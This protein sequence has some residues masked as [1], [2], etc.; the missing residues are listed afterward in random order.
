MRTLLFLGA[1]IALMVMVMLAGMLLAERVG[2][3][4]IWVAM[5]LGISKASSGG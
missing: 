1:E 5:W 4:L 2:V 3:L